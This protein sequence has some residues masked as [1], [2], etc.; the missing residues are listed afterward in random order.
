MTSGGAGSGRGTGGRGREATPSNAAY[1][2]NRFA[3]AVAF[4]RRATS[5]SYSLCMRITS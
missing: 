2:P 5:V 1:A 3:A 4:V